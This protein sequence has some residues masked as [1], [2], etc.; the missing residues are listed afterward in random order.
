M[1]LSARTLALAALLVTAAVPTAAHAAAGGGHTRPI[2]PATGLPAGVMPLRSP[3]SGVSPNLLVAPH[4]TYRGG[5]VLT[6]PVV[7]PVLWGTGKTYQPEVDGGTTPPAGL[8]GF[9]GA[10]LHS[11]YLAWLDEYRTAAT[12]IGGTSLEYGDVDAATRLTFTTPASVSDAT[13]QSTLAADA[14]DGTLPAPVPDGNGHSDTV[15]ALFFPAGTTITDPNGN[16]SMVQFC[17]YHGTT[18]VKVNDMNLTYLVLP[19]PSPAGGGCGPGTDAQV[20][21]SYTSHELVETMTDPDVGIATGTGAGVL[22]WY[23]DNNGEIS[24][25]CD[26]GQAT[27]DVA[28]GDYQVQK[29]W[30]NSANICL[31]DRSSLA[32]AA[33]TGVAARLN[34]DGSATLTWT[35]PAGSLAEYDVQEAAPGSPAGS[36]GITVGHVAAGGTD[37]TSPGP[38]DPGTTLSVAARSTSLVAS[39]AVSTPVQKAT[40]T[41]SVPTT[42]VLVTRTWQVHVSSPGP[43]PTGTV[44][45]TSSTGAPLGSAPLD[46]LGIAHVRAATAGTWAGAHVRYSGDLATTSA[47]TVTSLSAHKAASSIRETSKLLSGHRVRV[48]LD[49]TSTLPVTGRLTIK[50]GSATIKALTLTAGEHGHVVV[51]LTLARGRHTLTA[52]YAGSAT[53]LGSRHSWTVNV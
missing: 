8:G 20:L 31:A 6:N 27:D 14:A 5:R 47:Q 40:P 22:G 10:V 48:T 12:G 32:A 30:S 36:L 3:G 39:P 18:T 2:V 11:S 13:I 28:L 51:T 37:W 33:P 9:F 17:A 19:D 53:V 45:V 21:E 49:V 7:E 15:Y 26:T 29:A 46:S 16:K 41:V 34:S 23:D 35:P 42:S 25:I 24:D 52:T 4:L 43:I 1:S 50:N 44:T 38:V